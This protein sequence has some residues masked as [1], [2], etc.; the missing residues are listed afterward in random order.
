MRF[1]VICPFEFEVICPFE[2]TSLI[3]QDALI[4]V[5]NFWKVFKAV[6][7]RSTRVDVYNMQTVIGSVS[8]YSSLLSLGLVFCKY[9]N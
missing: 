4:V 2:D 3:Q 5:T 1:E 8:N 9:S 6:H 7:S